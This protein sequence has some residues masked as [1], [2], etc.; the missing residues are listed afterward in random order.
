MEPVYSMQAGRPHSLTYSRHAGLLDRQAGEQQQHSG[1][2][3][4]DAEQLAGSGPSSSQLWRRRQSSV[5]ASAGPVCP[6]L[7]RVLD[8][9]LEEIRLLEGG[10]QACN[11]LQGRLDRAARIGRILN[12]GKIR[13]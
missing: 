10:R 12:T 7:Q 4:L 3:R 11:T 1:A 13:A 5:A 6:C 9:Q 2:G 8:T